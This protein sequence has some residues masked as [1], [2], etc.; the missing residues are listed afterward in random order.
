MRTGWDKARCGNGTNDSMIYEVFDPPW[1][2]LPRWFSWYFL[3]RNR[4]R[5]TLTMSLN[6]QPQV[7]RCRALHSMFTNNPAIIF[8]SYPPRR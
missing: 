2:D 4:A 8:P 3:S 5:G 7:V 1:W 6:G